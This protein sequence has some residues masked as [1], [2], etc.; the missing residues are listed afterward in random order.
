[1]ELRETVSLSLI[2]LLSHKLRTL[3]TMLGII[4]GVGAVIA[5]LSIGEGAKQESL[6][7]IR[8]MGISNIIVQQ[9]DKDEDDE[10]EA[11]NT[12]NNRSQGLTWDDARSIDEICL[13]ADYVTPQRERK[14]KAQAHGNTF[15]TMA[16][17]TTA[18]YL[19]VL[20]AKMGSGV[21]FS[22]ADLRETKRVCVLGADA[23]RALFFFDDPLGDR[24]K[25]RNQWFTVI[26]V[27][28]DKGAAGGKI[29]GVL[30]VRNT[31][32]DIYIPLTTMLNRFHWEPGEAEL[33]QITVKIPTSDQLQEAAAILRTILNRRHRGVEDFKIAIPEE[34]LRQSQK[35]QQIFNI[36]MG[37]IAGI[38]L[39]VGGIGIMNIMLASVLERTRE[40]GIRRA[41]GARRHDI[42]SQF[43][44]ESLLVSL[45]GGLIGVVL[46]YAIPEVIT[47]YA[48]W[49]TIVQPWTIILAFG[50]SAIVGIGFG[51]YPARQA[52]LLNPIDALRYE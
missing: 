38:S 37:C 22:A 34:L 43:L 48:G 25:I 21:F 39:M 1:M 44:V 26:G 14:V 9:W 33:S 52:A 49:R 17:G 29:G 46:G 41:L 2:G 8:Q 36:V 23:K 30:E 15:R 24:V 4:F 51:I 50:V 12:D 27:L 10:S 31:D 45:F 40:I 6:E 20:D 7:Q 16:V 5:M 42:L 32:E 18:D 13:I 3:L 11:A 47:L 28:A 35:T 19:T